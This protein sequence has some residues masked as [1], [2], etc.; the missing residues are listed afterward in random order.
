[1]HGTLPLVNSEMR[2][3]GGALSVSPGVASLLTMTYR[4]MAGRD[5]VTPIGG[6]MGLR[7]SQQQRIEFLSSFI[8]GVHECVRPFLR[9]FLR[10]RL[11]AIHIRAF[12]Y[13]IYVHTR[14]LRAQNVYDAAVKVNGAFLRSHAIGQ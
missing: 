13:K 7:A 8:A 11:Y 5:D 9:S 14:G 2:V 12:V 6:Y 10:V 1:M 4:P 3:T